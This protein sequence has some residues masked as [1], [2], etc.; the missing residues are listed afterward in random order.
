MSAISKFE[1]IGRLLQK[2][3]ILLTSHQQK[4]M[5]RYYFYDLTMQ[6]I[7]EEQHITRSAVSEVIK[8]SLE[9]L[10][11]FEEK[12]QLLRRDEDI[13]LLLDQLEHDSSDRNKIINQIRD[14]LKHGI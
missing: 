8:Q 13:E 4:V 5:E 3:G 10:S 1:T 9:K 14:K 2:Y 11:E 7:A 6:E 12:L